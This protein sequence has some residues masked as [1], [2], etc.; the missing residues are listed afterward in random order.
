MTTK[1]RYSLILA[2]LAIFAALTLSTCFTSYTGNTGTLIIKFSGDNSRMASFEKSE[3]NAFNYE[4][5]MTGPDGKPASYGEFTNSELEKGVTFDLSL[6]IWDIEVKAKGKTPTDGPYDTPEGKESLSFPSS[7]LRAMGWNNVEIKAGPNNAPIQMK[8]ATE[9]TN[10][11]QLQQAIDLASDSDSK[12]EII[13]ISDNISLVNSISIAVGQNITFL[14]EKPVSFTGDGSSISINLS[15]NCTLILGREGMSGHLTFN[16]TGIMNYTINVLE[17]S[18]IMNEGV[19][20]KKS[21]FRGINVA[22]DGNFT[23]YGGEIIENGADFFDGGG[24]YV[25]TDG[26]FTM[27]GG[28]IGGNK[29]SNKA[30]NGGG[31]YVRGTFTMIDGDISNNNADRQG[32]GV[33]VD[34]GCEFTMKGGTISGN[35]TGS[36][37]GGGVYIDN[38]AK[39]IM[40][41]DATISGNTTFGNG[42]G[43]YVYDN[44]KFTMMNN[45]SISGNSS[46]KG[47][48]V[49]VSG[50]G[51]EPGEFLMQGG[52]ISGNEADITGGGVYVAGKMIESALQPNGKFQKT[53]GIIYGN[54]TDKDLNNK[55]TNGEIADESEG[56]RNYGYAVFVDCYYDSDSS[57][58]EGTKKIRDSTAGE[59]VKLDSATGDEW[60]QK[61]YY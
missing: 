58:F 20:I 19:T 12:E 49:Y 14:A 27:K 40:M 34:I 22:S 41:N 15:N 50:G 26:T 51:H 61:N 29:T 42:G 46:E 23:M 8:A 47:G 1:T 30:S 17:S 33:Y 31:V 54:N 3:I 32:G 7:M 55:V 2:I 45:T 13:L 21:G 57:S 56:D 36:G 35:K 37:N 24:V 28:T 38:N 5:I 10:E 43:V 9:V 53:G 16:W 11:W 48:G 25:D 4:I 60:I 6:G 39:F 18:L 59:N 44:A 52:T